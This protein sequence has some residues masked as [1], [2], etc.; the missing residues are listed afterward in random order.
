MIIS[1][2][3]DV[4]VTVA[5]E[6]LAPPHQ[7][8]DLQAR[9]PSHGCCGSDDGRHNPPSNSLALRTA[10]VSPAALHRTGTPVPKA[11]PL[12]VSQSAGE[13]P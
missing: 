10:G 2:Q 6:V 12:T 5:A 3:V 7:L 8:V 11:G 13:I 9:Q 1:R 4:A